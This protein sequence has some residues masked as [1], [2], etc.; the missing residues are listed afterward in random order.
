MSG[1]A[2]PFGAER[3][4]FAGIRLAC[5]QTASSTSTACWPESGATATALPEPMLEFERVRVHILSRLHADVQ[6]K[7]LDWQKLNLPLK[8]N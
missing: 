1:V 7:C 8:S 5:V 3:V 6:G 4:R 2:T